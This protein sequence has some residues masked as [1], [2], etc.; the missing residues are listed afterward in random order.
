MSRKAME[1]ALRDH[2]HRRRVETLLEM[3]GGSG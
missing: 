2:T 3:L 1:R